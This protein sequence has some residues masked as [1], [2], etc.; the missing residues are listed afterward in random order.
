MFVKVEGEVGVG[1]TRASVRILCVL[2]EAV[3]VSRVN[4]LSVLYA[5]TSGVSHL[6]TSHVG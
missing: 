3:R 4:I 2:R 1:A 5:L 6:V